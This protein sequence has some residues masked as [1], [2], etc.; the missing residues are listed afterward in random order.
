MSCDGSRSGR[1][2]IKAIE[3]GHREGF[4]PCHVLHLGND[5]AEDDRL[6]EISRRK[7]KRIAKPVLHQLARLFP[8]YTRMRS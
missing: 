6:S 8:E 7:R 3:L 1:I 5:F 4:D 2:I